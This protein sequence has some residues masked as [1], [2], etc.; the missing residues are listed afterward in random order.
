ME[1]AWPA[2]YGT[3]AAT[4]SAVRA[5]LW[6]DFSTALPSCQKLASCFLHVSSTALLQL[7]VFFKLV[8]FYINRYWRVSVLSLS[9]STLSW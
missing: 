8:C 6:N 3:G 5:D 2:V 4:S 7:S 9:L 1:P